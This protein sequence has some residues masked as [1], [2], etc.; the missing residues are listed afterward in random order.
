MTL[1]VLGIAVA[2]GACLGVFGTVF[3]LVAADAR[4]WEQAP[5]RRPAL[6]AA[7]HGARAHM[8]RLTERP[9]PTGLAQHNNRNPRRR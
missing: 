5:R 1:L 3:V 8:Y 2:A 7:R 4:R 9:S 6:E